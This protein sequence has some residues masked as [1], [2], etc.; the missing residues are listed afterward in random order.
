MNT[1]D[2]ILRPRQVADRFGVSLPTLWR[3][4][5]DGQLPEVIRLS[6]GCVGWRTSDIDAWVAARAEGP[7]VSRDSTAAITTPELLDALNDA[8]E[9]QDRAAR[10]VA[11]LLA[12]I[13]G[14]TREL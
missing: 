13:L 12:R 8:I 6:P 11:D 9:E 10:R 4:R 1:V 7:P 5:R 14:P 3:W 2:R